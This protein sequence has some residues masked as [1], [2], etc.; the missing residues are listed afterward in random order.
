M[1]RRPPPPMSTGWARHCS[2]RSPGMWPR[3]GAS[4]SRSCRSSCGCPG[5]RGPI[6]P[7]RKSGLSSS[8]RWPPIPPTGPTAPPRSAPSWVRPN[9][10]P[11]APIDVLRVR[12]HSVPLRQRWSP[13]PRA[14]DRTTA[15]PTPATK[16]RPPTPARATLVRKRLVE[17][18]RTN[19]H[20]RL[21]VVHAPS[22]FGKT[23]LAAHWYDELIA[24]GGAVA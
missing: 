24:H 13:R 8:T 6:S 11:A 16:Y 10:A 21:T 22:G 7:T 18:L 20:T 17:H 2:A 4:V 9:T 14:G 3:S 1:H 15:P 23:T 19:E 12:A 5:S